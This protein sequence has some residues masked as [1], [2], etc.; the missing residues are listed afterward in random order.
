MQPYVDVA[1]VVAADLTN[2]DVLTYTSLAAGIDA[3]VN[4]ARSQAQVSYRYERRFDWGDDAVTQDVHS[5]LARA[6]IGIGRGVNLE[7][8]AIATRSRSDIR[9]AA[10]GNFVGDVANVAQVYSLYAGPSVTTTSGPLNIAGSY[11]FG[12]TKVETPD[13]P[14]PVP[15]QRL[16]YFDTSTSHLAQAS[17]GIAAG[18]VAPVGVTL[19]G[20]YEREDAGQLDQT[21]E[22]WFGRGDVMLPLSGNVAVRAG[23]GYERI[24]ATQRDPLLDGTGNPV[25]DRN[26][27]FV[28]DPASPVRI[29]YETDGL[30]YDAGVIWRPSPRLELQ[31]NAGWRYGGETY[32][33]SLSYTPNRNVGLGVIV[34]DGIETFGRQVRDGL[35]DMPTAFDARPDPFGQQFSGCV[36]GARPGTGGSGAGGCLNDVF[37]SIA[38]ASY[39]ARGIDAVLSASYGRTRFGIGGGYANRRFNAPNGSGGGAPG[40]V[41]YGVED[42]S[43]YAQAFWGRDLSR[44]SAVDVTLFGNWS[45]SGLAGFAGAGSD[46]YGG[47]ANATYSLQLGRLGTLASLGVYGF[48]QEGFDTQWSAQALLGARYTF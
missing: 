40:V 37:Q 26:G 19:S 7:A 17:V 12:F 6:A 28:T 4:T 9:G 11:Y 10:P 16:D 18:D 15:G 45:S 43:A 46:V 42:Q 25:L 33:G 41:Y 29:A 2:D 48:D 24:E 47:G 13:V 30:I 27:R 36:F 3:G 20:A 21:Y 1:Q 44:V 22:G 32:F 34:Y 23:A 39:R 14:G 31:A 5:G 8:G 38:T 35:R